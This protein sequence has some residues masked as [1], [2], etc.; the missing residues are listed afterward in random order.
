MNEFVLIITQILYIPKFISKISG[1]KNIIDNKFH[2]KSDYKL[3][4]SF[5]VQHD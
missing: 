4:M 2:L 3:L 5:D 1:S